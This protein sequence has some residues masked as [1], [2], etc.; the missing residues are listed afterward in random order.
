MSER[1]LRTS[2]L[3]GAILAS[4]TAFAV[5]AADLAATPA[6]AAP[7][8]AA[9]A[10]APAPA[11]PAA[12][13]PDPT[14]APAATPAATPDPTPAPAPAA[15]PAATPAQAPVAG[16][17]LDDQA[18]FLAGLPVSAGSPLADWQKTSDYRDHVALM[19][20]EWKKLSDRLDKATAWQQA[21]LAP[22]I[23]GNRNL[24]YFFGGPDAVHALRLFPDAPTYLLAG[25]E[26]VGV[27]EAPE[28]MKFKDV[29][30]A[31]DGLAFGLRTFVAKSFFRTTEMGKDLQGRGI[32]GVLPVLYLM[33]SRS[34]ATLDAASFFEVDQKGVATDK[35]A[36]QKWGPGVP[37]V[38]V[39]F[40]VG[41]RALQEM[42]YVRVNLINDQ[43]DKQ[44]GFLTWA[45][46]Y[47]PANSFLKAA[48][49]ILHD[50]AFSKPRALLL[51]TSAAVV[52]DDSGIPYRAYPKGEWDFTCFG[53][54]MAPRDP[55][56]RQYQRDLDK[57][58]AEQP[59]K[60]LPFII[61][62][63]RQNDTFLLLAVKKPAAP[64]PAPAQDPTPAPTPAPAPAP[65]PA[66][67][68]TPA[69]TPAPTPV[70]TPTPVTPAAAAGNAVTAPAAPTK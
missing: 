30:A 63:R 11:A 28:K 36:G 31:I 4:L 23:Q 15:I 6:P 48:S 18:R 25:L 3:A 10:P 59:L 33:L 1:A 67:T 51:E 2:R 66:S 12:A 40:H 62:Y 53:K 68:P 22:R 49:F 46:G 17:T 44:P 34:G 29:H 70:P 16:S 39:R 57:A 55:F 9:P 45:R 21:E 60:P 13:T 65:A 26:P 8:T 56:E 43:L 19:D 64:A 54:Y 14:P 20:S 58:C 7:A 27:V 37:G 24:V 50:N 41:D 61:G 42:L 47:G 5:A 69:P 35:P 38:R 52:E 32:K